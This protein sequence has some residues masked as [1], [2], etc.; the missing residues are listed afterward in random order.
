MKKKWKIVTAAGILLLTCGFYTWGIPAVV[1][2]K[3]HK[4]FIENKIYENSGYIVDI[5]NPELSMGMFPSVWIKTDNFSILNE[6]NSKALSIENPRFKVKIFPLL[7]KKVEISKVSATKEDIYFVLSKEG[8]FQ[9]GEYPLQVNAKQ[10]F[11]LEKM[12]LNL[13]AYNVL[14]DDKL[15][16]QKLTVNGE[17]FEHGKFVQNKQLKFGTKGV[18]KVQDKATDYFADVEINLPINQFS[19]DKLKINAKIEDFD[20]SSIAEYAR[21]LSKDQLKDLNGTVN[22]SATT[23]DN[24]FGHKRVIAEVSTKNLEILGKDKAAS[25]IYK[26]D[27]T[28]KI[29]FTT[30]ENGVNFKNSTITSK[31]IY[32][33]VDGS[34]YKLGQKY[35]YLDLSVAAKTSRLDEICSLLPGTET[36]IPEF[37]LYKLKKYVFYGSGEGKIKFKGV[38]NRPFVTGFVKIRD[39]YL[40]HPIKGAPANANIDLNFV[41]KKMNLDVYVPTSKD[42]SVSVK[43]MVLIDGSKYS[44]LQ[45]ESTDSV[46][47]APAQEVLNP[48]HEILKFQLGPVPIL[49]VAGL[50]GIKLR[51]AGKKVD[52]HIWGEIHFRNVTASFNDIHNLVLKNGSGEVIFNDTQTT[53]KSYHATINGKPVEIKGDCS[54]LGKLNVLV[55][56]K[57]Q[58]IPQLI[59]VINT[60][61]ILVDIQKVVA[62][63]TNPRGVADVFLNIYGNAK[64]AETIEFNKD[65]FAKGTITLHNATTVMQDTYL[66]FTRVNGVVNFNQYD[67]DYDI[68]G[69]VR[70]SKIFVK[71][72]GSNSQIDLTA[73]S[74]RFAI[75][76]CN[77]LL[78]PKM[79]LPYQKEVGKIDVAFTGH[80]KGVAEA[81]KLDYNN[82]LVDGKF[83]S[84]RASSNPIK[85]NGGTFTIRKGELKTSQLSGLFNNN[86]Y[87]LSLTLTDIYDK[88]NISNAV[89]NFKNFDVSV[90]NV[91]KTQMKLPKELEQQMALISDIRGK[92]N[93]NGH[94]NNGKIWANTNLANISFVYKPYNTLVRIL[95]G[96]AKIRG[97]ELYLE[98]VNTKVSSMP[99]FIDGSVSDIYTKPNLHLFVSAKPTQ[100]FFDRFLNSKSVYPVK[101]KGDV[102]FNAHLRGTLERLGI[103][104][105]L[106]IGENSSIYYMGATLAGAPTG[107]IS[108]EGMTTNPVSLISDVVLYPNKIKLNYLRYNQTITSQN[109]RASV[110]NQL[111]ASGEVM[112]LK[113][114]VLGFKNLKITT[115]QPTNAKI[116]NILMKKPTI[117]QGVFTSDVIINGTSLA[118]KILGNLNVTSVDIPLLDSTIRDISVDFKNDFIYLKSKGVIL[119]NDIIMFAKILNKTEPLYVIDD[120]NV[121]MDVLDLNVISNALNDFDADYTRTNH[122]KTN[123]SMPVTPEQFIIKHAEVN[124]DKIL[125]KKANATNFKSDISLGADHIFNINKYRFNLANGTV[126]GRLSYNLSSQNGYGEMHIKNADASIIGENFFDMPGQMYG[127]VTGEMS[128]A[129]KGVTSVDC[130]NTLSGNGNFTVADGRMPKLGSLEY[131]LKAGNL[132][133]GGITGLSING[134]IDLITPLKTGNFQ[135]ISGSIKIKDGIANDIQVFSKGKDLNMY[136][137]GSY[138]IATLV[139]DMEVYGSLSKNF[140]TLLGR[141]GNASLNRLFSA[142]P[143]ISIN[144]INPKS[145]SNINK[146]PNFD[147]NNT[148]RVFKAEIYGDINGNN[149]VKSFRWIKD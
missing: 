101:L 34:I 141:I 110:Q 29:N 120:V 86:P 138:N 93:I 135:S 62:P 111:N 95:N 142:I 22:F 8:K 83:L 50:G 136:L 21:I 67:S 13:G 26:D 76:D 80:Y 100:V 17:Y 133:T 66:P 41:G 61:P 85:I 148:L 32:A 134:I 14:L 60:S 65:L 139:A 90:L 55:T 24:S 4:N 73:K 53:F 130:I 6:D 105:N 44:E 45:I 56:S 70:G 112:L 25:I 72:T 16:G 23:E 109:K 77:D 94:I 43:G 78:Y 132:I 122:I 68:N 104:S 15:N 47:L 140:S 39:G 116:F 82:V 147:K 57:G 113:D 69:Y 102:N 144:E 123:G 37:N 10:D 149:Y 118:P 81:G 9:L 117:K 28:A 91:V 96:Q 20:I 114:N 127:L 115:N 38:A 49:K 98:R 71:G 33:S 128:V 92:T 125:I 124:A 30:V 121:Q 126:D 97:N 137:T 146:I 75:G 108:S 84:N 119:T 19:E 106:N 51:S 107:T 54:V 42:Q 87:T 27:L 31:N 2:I 3:A 143:G 99:V 1:N 12:D 7:F 36:L 11:T 103:R 52:P 40:I 129:C 5:G 59:K 88:M 18:L 74:D 58:N 63:F 48:L 35:P 46:S 131:L 79:N 89:F 64:N 145:T